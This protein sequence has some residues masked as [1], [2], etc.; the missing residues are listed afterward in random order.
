V[1]DKSDNTVNLPTVDTTRQIGQIASRVTSH[2]TV[3]FDLD[4]D[5]R[6]CWLTVAF[7][8]TATV[9]FHGL[10]PPN[11]INAPALVFVFF[12]IVGGKEMTPTIGSYCLFDKMLHT[13]RTVNN[14]NN[15]S[16]SIFAT[17]LQSLK[18]PFIQT[19]RATQKT[20][21]KR[22]NGFCD[23]F[24]TD[25][26]GVFIGH[27]G[28]RET[29]DTNLMVAL[30]LPNRI[31]RINFTFGKPSM[32]GKTPSVVTVLKI[33]ISQKFRQQA[34]VCFRADSVG[35]QFVKSGLYCVPLLVW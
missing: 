15:R 26:I 21:T 30:K 33:V 16:L 4:S 6:F 22:P 29:T 20:R 24:R 17:I 31:R 3:N 34:F 19:S 32:N 12:P 13:A 27:H 8:T 10:T 9:S 14:G 1:I 23:T 2:R 18:D 11:A 35:L 7:L 25:S 5:N 28:I